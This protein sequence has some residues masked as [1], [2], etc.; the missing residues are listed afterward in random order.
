MSMIIDVTLN[1]P[2]RAKNARDWGKRMRDKGCLQE[3][4]QGR[5]F[6]HQAPLS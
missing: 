6:L 5:Y 1:D 2:G 3:V 4:A